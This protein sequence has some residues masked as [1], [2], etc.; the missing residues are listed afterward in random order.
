MLTVLLIWAMKM[1]R[2]DARGLRQL[3]VSGFALFRFSRN[4]YET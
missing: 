3:A 2:G 1:M 4:R